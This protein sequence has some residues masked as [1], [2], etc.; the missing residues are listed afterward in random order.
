M[1]GGAV[2]AHNSDFVACR[3]PIMAYCGQGVNEFGRMCN[4]VDDGR[5]TTDDR[6]R[7]VITDYRWQL[8]IESYDKEGT[9]GPLRASL[10]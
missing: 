1:K 10:S 9:E 6:R 4:T 7:T 2:L 5:P 3:I 8:I